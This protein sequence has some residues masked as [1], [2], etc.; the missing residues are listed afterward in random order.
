MQHD[1]FAREIVRFVKASP[2][3]LAAADAQAVRWR[4]HFRS[5]HEV[6]F[7]EETTDLLSEIRQ[8]TMQSPIRI[9]TDS[10]T[11]P[12][13]P[14]TTHAI[15]KQFRSVTHQPDG[16][17]ITYAPIPDHSLC[18]ELSDLDVQSQTNTIGPEDGVLFRSAAYASVAALLDDLYAGYLTH[19]FR[20]D[21]YGETWVLATELGWIKRVM[22]PWQ[23]LSIDQQLRCS[24][25][26]QWAQ[27]HPLASFSPQ[28]YRH[29]A[30]KAPETLTMIGLAIH[31]VRIAQAIESYPRILKHL[32]RYGIVQPVPSPQM[33]LDTSYR[34]Y[35]YSVTPRH[36]ENVQRNAIYVEQ[37]TSQAIYESLIQAFVH[38]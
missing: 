8:I 31:D 20:P 9:M 19:R 10:D 38:E 32:E 7:K 15:F 35:V 18:V 36:L 34:T 16:L 1:R 21:S 37:D 27:T 5:I 17:H 23:V 25:V 24:T 4:S 11:P 30:I 12:G 29:W 13:S 3:A 14:P 6:Y 28:Y 33:S 26:A 2:S 22:L